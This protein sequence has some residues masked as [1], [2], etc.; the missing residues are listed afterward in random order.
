MNWIFVLSVYSFTCYGHLQIVKEG[1][2]CLTDENSP[3]VPANKV[4]SSFNYCAY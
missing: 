4:V 2:G 1:L 3:A